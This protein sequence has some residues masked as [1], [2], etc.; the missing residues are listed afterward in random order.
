MQVCGVLEWSIFRECGSW[1]GWTLKY[2]K[3][4]EKR[5]SSVR[6]CSEISFYKDLL[7]VRPHN[8]CSKVRVMKSAGSVMSI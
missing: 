7:K 8:F 4:N 1:K 3:V 2:E 5:G 6:F